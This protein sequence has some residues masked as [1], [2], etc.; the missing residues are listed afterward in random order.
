MSWTVGGTAAFVFL[1]ALPLVW[2][3]PISRR[4]HEAARERLAARDAEV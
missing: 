1:L 2:R 4:A 3:Y